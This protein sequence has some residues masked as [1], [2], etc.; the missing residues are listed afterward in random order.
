M[1]VHVH[2]HKTVIKDI[3]CILLSAFTSVQRNLE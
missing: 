3:Y 2:V 1:Y